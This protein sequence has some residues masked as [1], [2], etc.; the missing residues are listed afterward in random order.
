MLKRLRIPL[1]A[2]V[3]AA[4]LLG[5]E[6]S[7]TRVDESDDD[8]ASN[9]NSPAQPFTDSFN[10]GLVNWRLTPNIPN[11]QMGAGNPLPSMEVGSVST[12]A[13]GGIT[14]RKFDASAGL[15]IEADVYWQ[16]PSVQTTADPELWIGLADE[17]DPTGTRGLAAGMWVDDA[18]TLHFQVNGA[19]IGT[20]TAPSV[21][22]WH[23]FAT[24]VRADRVVEFRVDGSLLFSGG[25]LDSWHL[26]RPVEACGIGYPERPR[27]DNVVARLP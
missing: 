16:A 19:D 11:N 6:R 3:L 8:P 20:A 25:S 12:L 4:P 7:C 13:T 24:T 2:L 26:V 27:I 10:G 14:V 22:N 15:V 23:R 21:S 17:E 1:I 5:A 18:G 9:P